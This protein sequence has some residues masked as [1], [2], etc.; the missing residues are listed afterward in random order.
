MCRIALFCLYSW[1]GGIK[2]INE[3]RKKRI[4]LYMHAN[5][6]SAHLWSLPFIG[7]LYHLQAKFSNLSHPIIDLLLLIVC[8]NTAFT[9]TVLFHCRNENKNSYSRMMFF[10]VCFS[11]R[12]LF[13]LASP[14]CAT[15]CSTYFSLCAPGST[16]WLSWRQQWKRRSR[17]SSC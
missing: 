13:I 15:R 10:F 4:I 8:S 11:H 6:P 12:Q 16:W 14:L 7:S 5:S 1:F 3:R 17:T 9:F 2:D